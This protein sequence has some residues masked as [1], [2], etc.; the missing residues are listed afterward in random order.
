MAPP[1]PPP[2]AFGPPQRKRSQVEKEIN[3]Y[4]C[5]TSGTV[6]NLVLTFHKSVLDADSVLQTLIERKL[7]YMIRVY[8]CT[9]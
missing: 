1:S 4:K 2:L 8:I 9:F 3:R 5:V 7:C 6:G